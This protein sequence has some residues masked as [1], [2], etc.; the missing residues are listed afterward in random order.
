[1]T[2]TEFLL[3]R[4]SEDEANAGAIHDRLEDKWEDSC[5]GVDCVCG[6]PRR[7]LAECA[8]KRAIIALEPTGDSKYGPGW[9]TWTDV[10]R[11]LARTYIDHPD[12]DE[13]WRL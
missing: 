6:V 3:A 9:D 5:A 13:A 1:M 8:S 12:S 10:V 11:L 7:V 2:I 4:I